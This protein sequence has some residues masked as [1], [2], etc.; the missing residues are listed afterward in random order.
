MTT[1]WTPPQRDLF[2]PAP[3]VSQLSE[4]DRRNALDMLQA[5][6]AE[7]MNHS[8]EKVTTSSTEADD[9]ENIV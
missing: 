4:V 9:D 7:A 1:Y 6:L 8:Q 5:L 2:E 3:P